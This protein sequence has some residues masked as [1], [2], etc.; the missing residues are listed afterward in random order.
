LYNYVGSTFVQS[1]GVSGDYVKWT[2]AGTTNQLT[3]PFAT[4]ASELRRNHISSG[5]LD[6]NTMTIGSTK[7]AIAANYYSTDAW[8]NA[9]SGM[10]YGAVMELTAGSGVGV[11]SGQLAW[12][13]KHNSSTPTNRLWWRARNSS[14]WG[15]DWK[16]I[17]FA[18]GFFPLTAGSEKPLTGILWMNADLVMAN[19][20][21][22][23]NDS[24]QKIAFYTNK[25]YPNIS[26]Y[27]QAIY[28]SS[29][30]RKRLSVFQK[31]VADWD[32][33]QT[34]VLSVMPD[35]KLRLTQ[36]IAYKGTKATYDMITFLDN[37][38]DVYGNGIAIGGGGMNH[39]QR[40]AG[41]G[42]HQ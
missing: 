24:S 40:M 32:T 30:G 35:G 16:E 20:N 22:T 15:D 28:E 11:L 38:S 17:A 4:R 12:D 10:S 21:N 13:V 39:R 31:N 7:Y 26:P 27:I 1:L 34:E 41:D 5:N 25:N 6:A 19:P 14:G 8:V 29:Y 3:V 18:D 9:P 36:A 33:P 2:K 23:T 37:T 42:H